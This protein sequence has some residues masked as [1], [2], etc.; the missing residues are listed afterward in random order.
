MDS[1]VISICS[2]IFFAI[3]L[4]VSL[5]FHQI[6]S[7]ESQKSY[8]H[9]WLH[10]FD[11]VGVR[12]HLEHLRDREIKDETTTATTIT[13]ESTKSP[14][15]SCPTLN[16]LRQ[17]P[18]SCHQTTPKHQKIYDS[19]LVPLYHYKRP[20]PST[21]TN[22]LRHILLAALQLN[23]GL[24]I[25][26]FDKH[27]S[28][29]SS[30]DHLI[31]FGLRVD[32]GILCKF[33]E[34]KSDYEI[35]EDDQEKY[36][37]WNFETNSS[38]NQYQLNNIFT[39]TY[40][41]NTEEDTRL[42]EESILYYIQNFT[43]LKNAKS[44]NW[45]RQPSVKI[46]HYPQDNNASIK[47]LF[48]QNNLA[49]NEEKYIGMANTHYWIYENFHMF[50]DE[51]GT[52]RQMNPIEADGKAPSHSQESGIEE[53]SMNM[54]MI[55]E[56]YRHTVHPEFV[57]F[58][59]QKF[60]KKFLLGPEKFL[61]VHWRFDKEFLPSKAVFEAAKISGDRSKTNGKGIPQDI[62]EM[63][64]E[65]IENPIYFLDK[66]I[67]HSTNNQVFDD[68]KNNYIFISSPQ[69]VAKQFQS[70]NSDYHHKETNQTFNIIN[71]MDSHNFLMNYA[72][73]SNCKIIIG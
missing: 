27:K 37:D 4:Y 21:Q 52:Y 34:I 28:D 56:I 17:I 63:F 69:S 48:M 35:E 26:N 45:I 16:S 36:P 43:H 15:F 38:D 19:Y 59:A 60:I 55:K 64:Y 29:K 13:P 42:D 49:F 20:G 6:S 25:T 50:I 31:P 40:Y 57:R 54:E 7:S 12:S 41:G 23:K 58:L 67:S 32:T 65:T 30:I 11:E 73:E 71:S 3:F 68:P 39:F 72:E 33:L 62:R 53:H 61:G 70:L 46:N 8:L 1:A 14:K 22:G 47:Y 2:L 10:Q 24:V 44:I 66:L 18:K 51:G 9:V 5:Y